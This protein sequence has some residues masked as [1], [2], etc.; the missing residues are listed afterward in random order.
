MVWKKTNVI[1]TT[2]LN[3]R[4][5]SSAEQIMRSSGPNRDNTRQCKKRPVRVSSA[6]SGFL[7]FLTV[8]TVFLLT[9]F[10]PVSECASRTSIRSNLD[11]TQL[12]KDVNNQ[13]NQHFRNHRECNHAYPKPHE[14][15]HI[16]LYE[17]LNYAQSK[18]GT[19]SI[20]FAKNGI[21][22]SKPIDIWIRIISRR[23]SKKCNRK[24]LISIWL[25]HWFSPAL[26]WDGGGTLSSAN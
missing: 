26:Y 23:D 13:P 21:Y 5:Y 4:S 2:G 24:L 1:C 15:R 16:I 6:A 17:K 3:N 18:I 7:N 14:V 20:F 8:S 9:S 19:R 12:D 22:I 10:S 11:Q 25:D